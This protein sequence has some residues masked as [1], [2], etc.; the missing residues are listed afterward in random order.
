[1]RNVC[2]GGAFFRTDQ[3]L[4]VG[5]ELKLNFLLQPTHTNNNLH[6]GA[7]VEV[8]GVVIRVEKEGMA[9][10]FREDFMI[11]PS[12]EIKFRKAISDNSK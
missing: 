5:T 4:P 8:S 12:P 2:A 3:E 1:M 7:S 6:S 10:C 9:V 11:F